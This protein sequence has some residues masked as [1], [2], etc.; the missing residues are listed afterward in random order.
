VQFIWFP[1]PDGS[2]EIVLGQA[3]EYHADLWRNVARARMAESWGIPE[4]ALPWSLE[5]TL[6]PSGLVDFVSRGGRDI[7]VLEIPSELPPGWTVGK[8]KNELLCGDK[9]QKINP[10]PARN[11]DPQTVQSFMRVFERVRQ[12][13]KERV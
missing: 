13:Q 12:T 5:P 8:I 11:A 1:N 3:N 4:K 9:I 2:W 7:L 10:T 6:I